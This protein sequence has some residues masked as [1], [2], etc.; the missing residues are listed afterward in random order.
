MLHYPKL[1]RIFRTHPHFEDH[2]NHI[3]WRSSWLSQILHDDD[4][5]DDEDDDDEDDDEDQDDGD[6]DRHTDVHDNPRRSSGKFV[7]FPCMACKPSLQ[8]RWWITRNFSES[9]DLRS[10]SNG[11]T[12][13][14]MLYRVASP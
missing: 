6:D 4:D 10:T 2:R 11:P 12:N 5:D 7:A 9:A 8:G 3:L 14:S 1:E 13:W